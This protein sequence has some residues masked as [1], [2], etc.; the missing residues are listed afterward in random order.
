MSSL[1]LSASGRAKAAY[2]RELARQQEPYVLSNI[3]GREHREIYVDYLR[4]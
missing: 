3:G 2:R 4:E 1:K